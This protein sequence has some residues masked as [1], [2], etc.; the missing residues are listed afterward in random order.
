[1]G[2]PAKGLKMALTKVHN[3]MVSDAL[4]NVRDYGA[5]GDA[6]TDDTAAIQAAVSTGKAILIPSGTFR[7]TNTITF[8]GDMRMTFENGGKI[9]ADVG[10]YS[11]DYALVAS[12]SIAQISDLS[13]NAVKGSGSLTFLSAPSLAFDDTI[14][15]FN[16]TNSS[17]SGFRTNYKAGEFCH[18]EGVSGTS[19]TLQGRL[20]DGYVSADVDVYKLSPVQVELIN[21]RVESVGSALGCIRVQFGR[22]V[23]IENP[24][25][26][27]RNNSCISIERCVDGDIFGGRCQNL[28]DGGDDYCLAISNSQGLTIHGGSWYARRHATAT[29]GDAQVGCV[30]VRSVRFIGSR[31]SSDAVTGSH[32]AD[33]H[34]NTEHSGYFNCEING[35]VSLQGRDNFLENCNVYGGLSNGPVL[36]SAEIL[37]GSFKIKNNKFYVFI[38]PQAFGRGV[39]D[40]GGNNDAITSNTT[41][42]LSIEFTGNTIISS[43]LSASTLLVYIRN[44]GTTRKIS[45]DCSNNFFDVNDFSGALWLRLSSG[46]ADSNFIIC[47]NN[48]STV[49]GKYSLYPDAS[50]VNGLTGVTRAQ[51]YRWVDS[52]TTSTGS[53]FAIGATVTFQWRFPRE[54]AVTTSKIDST[55]INNRVGIVVANP[56]SDQTSRL[57]LATDDGTNF[58]SALTVKV[59]GEA[60]IR[61]V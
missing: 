55:Y 15:I 28:G 24:E 54:P 21:P 12:G 26:T 18:L 44:A 31:I 45:V 49:S 16:P 29:G 10:A 1:M 60:A 14:I 25:I 40:F 43:V 36:Y 39:V 3:R 23:Y 61:E 8:P 52:V 13:A 32:A 59:C 6:T 19:V 7:I 41:G 46:T 57:V 48:T 50:Y 37:G 30:P 34:G 20:Y 33:F 35:G 56:V 53:S 58:A 47:D 5:A 17:W 51:G 4:V 27:D 38:D 2:R 22:N 9:Y 42:D 11:G